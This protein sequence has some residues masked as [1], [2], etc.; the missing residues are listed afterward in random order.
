M[1]PERSLSV[2]ENTS[3]EKK[4][5]R[6]GR[7][8][9]QNMKKDSSTTLL[10]KTSN[11]NFAELFN[12]TMSDFDQLRPEDLSEEDIKEAA[13]LR[14]TKADGGTAL[15]QYR[16]VVKSAR[17]GR[18]FAILGIEQQSEVDYAM[19]FRVLELDFVNYARQVQIIRERHEREWRDEK[20]NMHIL[21]RVCTG[22]YLGR[23]IAANPGHFSNVSKTAVNAL[24]EL[25]HSPQLQGIL[26]PQY[27]TKKGGFNMCKGLDGMI[28]E[29][30][31]KGMKKGILTGKQEMAVSLSA[32]G[33]S[34]EEIAKAAKVS[35]GV[36]RS[37][38]SGN[39]G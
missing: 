34:V 12:R 30:I 15:V 9:G 7:I 17:N 1:P 39:A 24:A 36:V 13:Y 2:K 6:R 5:A 29:G 27:R 8:A 32:M 3:Q 28:Q 31:Q 4:T 23:F 35:E 20:G 22:E 21:G 14:I 25:T 18:I 16:D 10:F 38:L 26:T 11:E 33:M 19:P 37:W